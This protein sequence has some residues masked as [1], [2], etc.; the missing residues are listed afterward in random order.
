MTPSSKLQHDVQA[1]L[2]WEPALNASNIGVTATESG[3][4]TLSGT[5]ASYAEKLSARAGR[6]WVSAVRAIANDIVVQP[7]GAAHRTD[8]DLAQA[9]LRALEWDM[10]VPDDKM[11]VRVE[12]G[13]VT[14]EGE[15]PLQFQRSAAENAVC[16]L[17]GVRGVN[18]Q[19]QLQTRP[20]LQTADVKH[21][22]RTAFYRSAEIDAGTIE[23]D[24]KDSTVILRGKVRTWAERDAAE[25]AA[26]AAPGV[27]AVEDKLIVGI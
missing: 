12:D 5:V 1:E 14:L 4:V 3:V 19:I 15:V 24:T 23:V 7:T 27:L 21:A 9:A 10:A 13:R 17:S 16:R 22:V 20:S 6:Q 18:N 2:E 8:T 26:W 25:R 11:R